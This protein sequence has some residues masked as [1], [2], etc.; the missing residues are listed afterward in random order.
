MNTLSNPGGS[1]Q[2][3]PY[4]PAAA[5]S[6]VLFLLPPSFGTVSQLQ[7]PLLWTGAG[8]I[9]KNYANANF[10]FSLVQQPQTGAPTPANVYANIRISL[11]ASP[12]IADKD[13]RQ[14]LMTSFADFLANLETQFE[15]ESKLNPT[16]LLV[17]GATFRIGQQIADNLPAPLTDTLFYRYALSSG[18]PP[19]NG[20]AYVDLRPGMRMRVETEM[21]QFTAP[22]APSNFYVGS[23]RFLYYISSIPNGSGPRQVV[24]DP[25]L[26]ALRAPVIQGAGTTPLVA[27]GLFDL[28]PVSGLQT[29]WRLFYPASIPPPSAT[30]DTK[31]GDNVA[32]LGAAT[33]AA[34]NQATSEYPNPGAE[35]LTAVFLG[36]AVIVPEIP[37]WLTV[38]GEAALEYVSLGTTITQIIERFTAVPL[39]VNQQLV[40]VKRP[41]AFNDLANWCTRIVSQPLTPARGLPSLSAALFDVPLIA[42]D[43]I[44]LSLL[45]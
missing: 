6:P 12:F 20:N 34:L 22:G 4:T 9:T 18:L 38:N 44:T 15:I 35:S 29:Y 43:N 42:G 24:F 23:G 31:I 26:G 7:I 33:L 25:F 30:G 16:P 10:S 3:F 27:G 21:K 37:I 2:V 28:Q 19:L 41:L 1:Y 8:D 11:G 13:G 17:P 45:G 14:A 36:R 40:T 32:L 5:T 39:D